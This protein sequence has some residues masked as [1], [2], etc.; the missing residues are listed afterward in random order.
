ME[1]KLSTVPKISSI[2]IRLPEENPK[3]KRKLND[4][5]AKTDEP[6]VWRKKAPRTPEELARL[7]TEVP[8]NP[9]ISQINALVKKELLD[10]I[11]CASNVKIYISTSS[12][13]LH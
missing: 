11:D 8:A 3:K 5:S 10:L 1:Q 12:I 2:E 4:S 7:K 9:V 13:H 6:I